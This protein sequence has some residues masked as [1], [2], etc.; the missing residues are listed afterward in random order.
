MTIAS[1]VVFGQSIKGSVTDSQ[2]G[3]TL[4]GAYI[5]IEGTDNGTITDFD[6]TYSLDNLP[7]GQYTLIFS[8]LSYESKKIS[9]IIVSNNKTTQVNASLDE[10]GVQ[11]EDIQIVGRK[12]TD[13]DLS[14]V[15]DMR[16]SLQVV[17]GISSQQIS[18]S[19]DK[20]ASEVVRRV[21]GTAIQND[22]FIIVR[23]LNQRYNNIW[24]NHAATPSSEID[25]RAF[26]FDLIPS[27][28]IDNLRIYKS[29]SPE[30]PADFSGGFIQLTTKDNPSKTEFSIN[31]GTTYR[32]GS[33]FEPFISNNI[34]AADYFGFSA[35]GKTLPT[36]FPKTLNNL[37]KA[38][39]SSATQSINKAWNT[40]KFTAPLDQNLSAYFQ[41]SL[42]AKKTQIGIISGINYGT[43]FTSYDIT[44]KRFGIYQKKIDQ[45]F[46]R[47]DYKDTQYTNTSKLGATFNISF[48]FDGENRLEFRNIF[49]Q[50]GKTQVT[51]RTGFDNNNDYSIIETEYYNRSRSTFMSQLNGMHSFP[52]FDGAINWTLGYVYTNC[53][54]PDRRIITSRLNEDPN[55]IY[56][57]K[58]RTEGNDVKRMYQYLDENITSL[59]IDWIQDFKQQSWQPKLKAGIYTEYKNRN[60]NAR[61]FIYQFNMNG[62]P[63]DF[64]YLPYTEM[65]SESYIRADGVTLQE[66]TNKSDSYQAENINASI[67]AA[68]E[69]PIGDAAQIYAGVRLE[70]NYLRLFGYESDGIKPVNINR[71]TCTPFPPL[72]ASY[73]INDQHKLRLSYGYAINRPEFREIVPYVYYGFD[74]FSNFEGNPSLQDAYSHNADFRYEFYFPS[75]ETISAAVFYKYFNHPIET[76]YYEVGG[77][78]QYTYTN[79][80]SAQNAGIEIEFRK[81]LDF[82]GLPDF[83]V[84]LNG[85]YIFSRIAFKDGSFERNRAMQGQSPYLIN[86]SLFYNNEQIGLNASLQYNVAGE[87]IVAIGVVNQDISEDIPNIYEMPRHML[88]FSISKTLGKYCTLKLGC[89]DMLNTAC[90]LKQFPQF[91]KDGKLQTREQIVR[92]YTPGFQIQLGLSVKF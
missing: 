34:S 6:G 5:T 91:E 41:T 33:S 1:A 73:S 29:S 44:N 9:N 58:Y 63:N 39:N 66:N 15:K 42:I 52:K 8:F 71:F 76:T 67:Y 65:F 48:I 24:V 83:Q 70:N 49:N 50:I 17:S 38:N 25:S 11:L 77:Q 61:N 80:E 78:Y 74:L 60:L 32:Y 51:K 87:R 3:E 89:K 28:L 31:Y 14:L 55:S 53:Y 18:K 2:N 85:S 37:S 4:P 57:N 56:N 30:L 27:G 36:N 10:A 88:D 64:K 46:A 59:S 81:S 13:T 43:D 23:G 26:S 45:E 54:E 90:E 22:R 68:L 47:N 75:G 62:L 92:S 86:A 72:N 19:I 7:S 82:M 40:S 35:I 69:M 79:A 21:S 20:D 16:T 84:V 12:R